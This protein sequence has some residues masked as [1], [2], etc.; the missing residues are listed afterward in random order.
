MSGTPHYMA[1]EIIMDPHSVAVRGCGPEVDMWALGCLTYFLLTG[2]TPFKGR[3]N[4]EVF[5][6]VIAGRWSFSVEH[7]DIISP[8]SRGLVESLLRREA[9]HR[10]TASALMQHKWIS[11]SSMKRGDN[12]LET[13]SKNMADVMEYATSAYLSSLKRSSSQDGESGNPNHSK[14]F[15]RSNSNNISVPI[16][17]KASEHEVKEFASKITINSSSSFAEETS[18]DFIKSNNNN[19]NDNDKDQRHREEDNDGEEEGGEGKERRRGRRSGLGDFAEQKETQR[20]QEQRLHDALST[21]SSGVNDNNSNG[22]NTWTHNSGNNHSSST[23][24]DNSKS[25]LSNLFCCGRSK[26]YRR[27]SLEHLNTYAEYDE[28]VWNH[29][30]TDLD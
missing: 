24:M 23:F 9:K 29:R 14:R 12:L 20:Q 13:A 25:M 5:N 27:D 22:R 18:S 26:L 19:D 6:S 15:G 2:E 21:N 4:D 16:F 28:S 1:P 10:P 11:G 17:N 7:Q 8:M 3:T 30:V